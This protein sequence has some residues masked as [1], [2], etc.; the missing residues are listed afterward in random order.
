M[1]KTWKRESSDRTN[2]CGRKQQRGS[3]PWEW[4]RKARAW[5]RC[6]EF[7][8]TG[9]KS[10]SSRFTGGLENQDSAFGGRTSTGCWRAIAVFFLLAYGLWPTTCSLQFHNEYY[11]MEVLSVANV[12]REEVPRLIRGFDG[13]LLDMVARVDFFFVV[14]QPHRR[15][16]GFTV[17]VDLWSRGCC[18]AFGEWHHEADQLLAVMSVP[19]SPVSLFLPL[20]LHFFLHNKINKLRAMHGDMMLLH[21]L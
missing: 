9:D 7:C 14:L 3:Y 20:A 5:N 16:P 19:S 13:L 18:Y 21:I 8:R 12:I 2:R 17:E 10:T 4:D 6:S 1:K 15:R 11:F